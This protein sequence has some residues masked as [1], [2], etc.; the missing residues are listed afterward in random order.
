M[1]PV[2]SGWGAKCNVE[3]EPEPQGIL[4]AP[5]TR[6]GGECLVGQASTTGHVRMPAQPVALGR[7]MSRQEKGDTPKP[8]H[9]VTQVTE[10]NFYMT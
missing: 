7:Q 3:D 2:G 8:F 10:Q 4:P 6:P 1:I 9:K 5:P